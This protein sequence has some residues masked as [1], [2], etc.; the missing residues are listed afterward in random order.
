MFSIKNKNICP[1]K[2]KH[3]I[4]NLTRADTKE[5]LTLFALNW[6]K[7]AL[8]QAQTVPHIR[9]YSFSFNTH[10]HSPVLLSFQASPPVSLSSKKTHHH[11]SPFSKNTPSSLSTTTR[12]LLCRPPHGK[13]VREDYLVVCVPWNCLFTFTIAITHYPLNVGILYCSL[14]LL[15]WIIPLNSC[16]F[17]P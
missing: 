11:N 10:S 1:C 5:R 9:S 7:M 13:H 4:L 8:L 3:K 15:L 6:K 17:A 12:K 16:V 2:K 14:S